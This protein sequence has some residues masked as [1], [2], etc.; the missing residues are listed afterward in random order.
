[1]R[2][3]QRAIGYLYLTD[4]ENQL[5]DTLME[6]LRQFSLEKNYDL[7][8]VIIDQA[9]KE[10]E[11]IYERKGIQE[12]FEKVEKE[13]ARF[14]IVPGVKYFTEKIEERAWVFYELERRKLPVFF[15]SVASEDNMKDEVMQCI[16]KVIIYISKAERLRI[17]HNLSGGRKDKRESGGFTGG[18][19]PLGYISIK[20]SGELYI[21]PEKA[22]TVRRIFSLHQQGLSFRA[23]AE[24]MNQEGHTTQNDALFTSVQIKR[25]LDRKEQYEGKK[26]L[27]KLL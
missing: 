23:I 22:E 24:M 26:D 4:G 12:L 3:R 1:M 9:P 20:G 13:K 7:L 27:P 15:L 5:V 25:T 8:N 16:K 21:D 11:E 19:A 18:R 6:E 14:V 17:S 2:E 10:R